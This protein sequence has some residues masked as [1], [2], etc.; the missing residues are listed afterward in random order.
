MENFLPETLEP[1][2]YFLQALDRPEWLWAFRIAAAVI[3]VLTSVLFLCFRKRLP[4]EE[5]TRKNSP[6]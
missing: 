2:S 1:V 4:K 5:K 6:R 3:T